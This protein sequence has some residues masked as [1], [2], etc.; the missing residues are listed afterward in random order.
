MDNSTLLVNLVFGLAAAS[1]GAF[2]AV[3][4]GQ[5]VTLGYILAGIAIGP[6]SPGFVGDIEA[7]QGLADIGIIF[8][9]F[10]IGVQLSFR[11]LMR[12]G[13]V[14]IV[15][16]NLQVLATILVGY[17]V[18]IALGFGPLEALIFGAVISNSSS[19]V[20]TKIL[21]DRG[22]LGS[23]HSHISLGWS[24]IQDLGTVVLVVVFTA[25]AEGTSGLWTDL[26][27]VAGR[28]LLF[29]IIL[30]PV[31]LIALPWLFDLIASFRNR[32]LFILTVA[33][34]A[35][36]AAYLATFFGLSIALGAFVAGVTVGESDLS[37][38][39]LGEM[40]PLRDVFAGLFFV[41]VGMLV[42][43][44][45]V[46]QNFALV[47]LTIG[48]IVLGKGAISVFIA[49]IFGYPAHT[50]LLVGVALAQCAEFSFL[51]ARVGSD[52]GAVTPA[53]FNLMMAGV[54][55]SMVLSPLL[56]QI[57]SP[58]ARWLD[59]HRILSAPE[60]DPRFIQRQREAM[61][62]EHAVVCGY[63]RVG[64]IVVGALHQQGLPLIVIDQDQKA[65]KELREHRIAALLGNAANPV[66]LE[67]AALERA[68]V[69]VIA[70]PDA[71]TAR[72]ITDY[73]RV[74]NPNLDIVVRTHSWEER[75]FL[76]RRGIGEVVMGEL[77][78]ALEMTLH[79]LRRFGVSAIEAQTIVQWWRDRIE[80]T[81]SRDIEELS[82]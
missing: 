36:S 8:L 56:H 14:A 69:L 76:L 64:R 62:R 7:V 11:E 22:E 12:V 74:A 47:L 5:S 35:L 1:V 26:L 24:S 59:T 42:N 29:I 45:F 40:M 28:A 53:V 39:I 65:V 63:G 77:E 33:T 71:L 18:G 38:Q 41:S 6:F 44:V 9:M 43:P 27:W 16:A 34:V 55:G 75:D 57:S 81:Q 66:L 72:Q 4:L 46:A 10:S 73:A 58:L 20:L 23:L 37:L 25:L 51:L 60:I 15:G 3:R 31:G 52:L 54:A 82:A 21:S 61:M 19:T 48:L 68:R 50:A 32:E 70:T 49:I 79:T 67:N 80:R 2:L 78:L 13:K 30:V 17:L